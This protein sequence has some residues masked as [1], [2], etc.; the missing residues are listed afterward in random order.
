ML[1]VIFLEAP[2]ELSVPSPLFEVLVKDLALHASE[3]FDGLGL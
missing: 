1:H 3:V 2:R